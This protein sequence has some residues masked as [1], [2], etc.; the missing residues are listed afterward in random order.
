[1]CYIVA[2]RFLIVI[3]WLS[4][5]VAAR[6]TE[7][8]VELEEGMR[9]ALDGVN[10]SLLVQGKPVWTQAL[11]KEDPEAAGRLTAHP[12][13]GDLVAV[14]AV[15]P[16]EGGRTVEA[17]LVKTL[18]RT[19]VKVIWNEETTLTGDLGERTGKAVRFQ[20]LTGDGK[21]EIIVGE[22]NEMVHLCGQSSLPLLFRNV[23]DPKTGVFRPVLAKRPEIKTPLE[24]VGT[25]S[26]EAPKSPLVEPLTPASASRSPG[27]GGHAAGLSS[28]SEAMDRNV[29]TAWTPFPRNG[30]GEFASFRTASDAY[31]ITRVG[32]RALAETAA[33]K[34][35][36]VYDRPKTLLLT[37]EKSVYRLTFPS[38]PVEAP[39]SVYWFDF[40]KPEKT[41]CMSIVVETSFAPSKKRLLPITEIF[42]ET[43]LD[44]PGGLEL[45]AADLKDQHKR[46]QAARLLK[47]FGVEGAA[48]IRGA[49]PGL[50]VPGRRLA[51][52]ILSETA[53]EESIG[54]LVE[55]LLDQDDIIKTTALKGLA[56]S[57]EKAVAGL[58][59]YLR[60]E[61]LAVFEVAAEVLGELDVPAAL[62]ALVSQ[63]GKGNRERRATLRNL[64][65]RIS[66]HSDQRAEL[67]FTHLVA[68]DEAGDREKLFDL[69]R[70]GAAAPVLGE[71]IFALAGR[72]YDTS[73]V[74]PDRYRAL[75]A[76]GRLGCDHPRK[77]LLAAASDSDA[78]IRKVA[79][80]GLAICKAPSAEVAAVID[81][82]LKDSATVVRLAGLDAARGANIVGSR[83]QRVKAISKN[84]P[85]PVVRAKST[86]LAKYLPAPQAF[87]ILEGAAND[88]SG[89]VREA[90]LDGVV[91]LRGRRAD[92]LVEGR[93]AAEDESAKIKLK[94]A[95]AAG[96]RCQETAVPLLLKV[97]KTGAEPLADKEDVE[98][99]V[100]AAKALGAI[101]GAPAVS[102]LKEASRRSN[103]ATDRAI[104]AALKENGAFCKMKRAR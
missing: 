94:A 33:S 98:V 68:A 26:A 31:G 35:K 9:M 73:D 21:P 15:L 41:S 101:G 44:G 40:P 4:V 6:A 7:P 102:A 80:E 50:D 88:E 59:K 49:W 64:L 79:V 93:L 52:E 97:L 63:A 12:L 53:P 57:P 87:E 70:A 16:L 22:L 51:V 42:A 1:L 92:A 104:A 77:R 74:F 45:L 47:S 56:A 27:D 48:A 39:A 30:A 60:S 55:A 89:M 86:S 38:D 99:A 78:L 17:V 24:L 23:F 29:A 76:M 5:S 32:I 84:D 13:A 11:A 18:G 81:S 69:L 66:A 3:T 72:I 62:T 91:P 65:A 19:D 75:E 61:D 2:M 28:P 8:S 36:T 58:E 20:D 25:A 14:H 67:L 71:R 96:R 95:V 43:E 54:L 100:A 103:P 85:W 82:A 10:L 46:R 34:K 37:T 90:V 83:F